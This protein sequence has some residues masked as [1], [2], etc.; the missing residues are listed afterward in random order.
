MAEAV[1]PIDYQR[2]AR[3]MGR[4]NRAEEIDVDLA[5][6][7][8]GPPAGASLLATDGMRVTI[9]NAGVGV[10]ALVLVFQDTTTITLDSTELATGDILDWGFY[11][12]YVVNAAQPGLTL[13]LIVDY[14]AGV[15]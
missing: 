10:W 9:L 11:Q 13:E 6:A 14:T 2:F 15:V 8:A 3:A 7:H 12:L 4:A 5:V 1:G